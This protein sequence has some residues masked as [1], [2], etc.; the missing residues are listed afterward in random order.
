MRNLPVDNRLRLNK[1]DSFGFTLI[2]MLVVVLV[3]ALLAGT[4]APQVSH[5][6]AYNKEAQDVSNIRQACAKYEADYYLDETI[7]SSFADRDVQTLIDS[8][9]TNEQAELNYNQDN[10]YGAMAIDVRDGYAY[11]TYNPRY[12]NDKQPYEWRLKLGLQSFDD[13]ERAP[14]WIPDAPDP[15]DPPD[16][17]GPSKPGKGGPLDQKIH[18]GLLTWC[19]M[20]TGYDGNGFEHVMPNNGDRIWY[21]TGLYTKVGNTPYL[22]PEHSDLTDPYFDNSSQIYEAEWLSIGQ[23]VHYSNNCNE[24]GHSNVQHSVDF[25]PIYDNQERIN[26]DCHIKCRTGL[27]G[28]EFKDETHLH[29]EYTDKNGVMHE[30]FIYRLSLLDKIDEGNHRNLYLFCYDYFR[31]DE[32]GVNQ[33]IYPT[34]KS[35]ADAINLTF[36]NG[37]PILY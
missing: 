17:P 16:P 23:S 12:V 20:A 30:W 27:C 31:S 22:F 28:T 34:Y 11:I 2:E 26:Q 36:G 6:I 14:E 19:E 33:S 1:R 24:F 29:Y 25:Q 7:G 32:P 15:P 9:I 13:E 5:L 3:I 10:G 37:D 18:L 4:A 35:T 21:Q 8:M